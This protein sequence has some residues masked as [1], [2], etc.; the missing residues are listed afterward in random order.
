MDQNFIFCGAGK[1]RKTLKYFLHGEDLDII[2]DR[3]AQMTQS[4]EM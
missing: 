1:E 3:F 4:V 2:L